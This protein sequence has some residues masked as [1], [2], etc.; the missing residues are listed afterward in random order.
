METLFPTGQ[1]QFSEKRGGEPKKRYEAK[2][3]LKMKRLSK[4]MVFGNDK[5]TPKFGL[6]L[7]EIICAYF[8]CYFAPS[9]FVALEL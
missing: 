5:K 2:W 9:Y 6:S 3:L 1:E 8:K 7:L 4:T